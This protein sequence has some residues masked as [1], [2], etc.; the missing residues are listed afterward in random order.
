VSLR[1]SGTIEIPYSRE[2]YV[3]VSC[4]S[5]NLVGIANYVWGKSTSFFVNIISD[6]TPFFVIDRIINVLHC[7]VF[8]QGNDAQEPFTRS[9][10]VIFNIAV[11]Q[12]L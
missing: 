2:G 6:A 9:H 12:R 11:E 1:T 7:V 10:H 5:N 8:Q 3:P 4:T